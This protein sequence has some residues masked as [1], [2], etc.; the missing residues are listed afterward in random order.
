MKHLKFAAIALTCLA[1]A[2]VSGC[3]S[4]A[5]DTPAAPAATVS[6]T[7]LDKSNAGLADADLAALYPETQ[8]TLLDLRGNDLSPEAVSALQAALPNCEILWSI[9]LGS[10]RFD[11]SSDE[12][13]LPAD[14]AA[15]EL[16]RLKL[17]P[18]LTRVDATAC[19]A[20][21]AL[22]A[23]AAELPNCDIAWN[24]DVLGQSYPASTTS[25]DLSG[26]VV[27]DGAALAAALTAFPELQQVDLTGQT[28]SDETMLALTQALPDTVFLW[29]IDLFGVTVGSGMT[30]ADISDMPVDD[31]DALKQKLAFLPNLTQLVMCNC[32]PSSEEMETLV[33]AYPAI[34]FVWMIQVGAWEM[35]T[36]VKAFSKGN[37]TTFDGGRFVGGKTNFTTE[38]IEP[39]KYCTDLIALDLGHGNR[40]T[41]LDVLQY[42]PK[43]RFLIVAMNRL[44]DIEDL[45]YCPDLEYLEIFQNYIS[46]WTPLLSLTKLTHLNCS[47]NYGKGDGGG[48]VYPDYTVL[49]QMT[50][51]QRVWVIHCNLSG[52]QMDDLRAALPNAVINSVGTHSTSNGWRDNDL[53]REMQGLFNLPISD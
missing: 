30:E 11:S 46:D 49:K 28:L 22:K 12:I 24:V 13:T 2:A 44:T 20:Y 32:G 9:P 34:K 10:S 21:D 7:Q 41:D 40:I 37:R 6:V 35:R 52:S 14:T 43:L 26:A 51:L 31:L 5:A 50:Q 16:E 25:L 42:L 53:Y 17:F 38:D 47:T 4:P 39:L 29:S 19:A 3:A 1:L 18:F 15:E 23:I 45:K 48:R 33:A 27:S 8:L 36:D